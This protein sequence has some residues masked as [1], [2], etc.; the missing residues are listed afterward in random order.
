MPDPIFSTRL[1]GGSCFY[2][3]HTVPQNAGMLVTAMSPYD[4]SELGF[5]PIQGLLQL[6]Q[7]VT[8]TLD[9]H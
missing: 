5:A 4:V 7:L 1:R 8:R 6:I 2:R 3:T 9:E